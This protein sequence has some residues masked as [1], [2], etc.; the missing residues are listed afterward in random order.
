MIILIASP[1]GLLNNHYFYAA[2]SGKRSE[3]AD[4]CSPE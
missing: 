3:F 1:S 2:V 4:E